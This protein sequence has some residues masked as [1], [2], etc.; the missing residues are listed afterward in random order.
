MSVDLKQLDKPFPPDDLDWMITPGGSG[1]GRNGKPYARIFAYVKVRAIHERLDDVC[2]PAGW[3][4]DFAR[5]PEGGVLC[6]IKILCELPPGSNHF[7]WVSKWDGVDPKD[8]TG[9]KGGQIDVVK[10][11]ITNA[12]KRAAVLW[13]IGR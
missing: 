5:G 6:G 3:A 10:T 7:Q 11:A 1:V 8:S 9:G 4:N 12:F 13:G 2:G